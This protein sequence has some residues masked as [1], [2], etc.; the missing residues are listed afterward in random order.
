MAERPRL[1]DYIANIKSTLPRMVSDIKELA[2]AEMSSSVKHAGMG[3]GLFS[4]AGI[5]GLFALNCVLWAAVFGIANFYH[6]I[7]GR[8]WF[9]ALALAFITFA[10]ILLILAGILAVIGYTQ[11]KKVKAPTATIAE[12]KATIEALTTGLSAGVEDAQAGVTPSL[13]S[14]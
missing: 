5:F 10:V 7:A 8:D 3:G 11:V 12:T 4:G 2:T 13:T 1:S 14:H 6:Y 9:T